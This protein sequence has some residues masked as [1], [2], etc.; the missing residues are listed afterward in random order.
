MS[1][2]ANL[3]RQ[4]ADARAYVKAWRQAESELETERLRAL[5]QLTETES[6]QHFR[7][8]AVLDSGVST[9]Q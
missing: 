7:P 6:A 3:S 1:S 2:D 8:T 5:R 4:D 9:T